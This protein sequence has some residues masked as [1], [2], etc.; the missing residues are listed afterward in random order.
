MVLPMPV[1]GVGSP[2]Q[3]LTPTRGA[4]RQHQPML[5]PHL[6]PGSVPALPLVRLCAPEEALAA[7]APSSHPLCHSGR[8]AATPGIEAEPAELELPLDVPG[9]LVLPIRWVVSEDPVLDFFLDPK[10]PSARG[11][12][13]EFLPDEH[14]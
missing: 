2:D 4:G 11:G 14:W 5:V 1:R 7:A 10:M 13:E 6:E 9:L 12:H 3:R 8:G